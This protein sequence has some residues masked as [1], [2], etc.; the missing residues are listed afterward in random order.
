MILFL[1]AIK[2]FVCDTVNSASTKFYSPYNY[3]KIFHAVNMYYKGDVR[4]A[5]EVNWWIAFD[6]WRRAVEK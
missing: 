1:D 4:F 3:K 6:V 5:N 2:E